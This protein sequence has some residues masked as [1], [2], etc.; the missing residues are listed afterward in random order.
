NTQNWA[1]RNQ[2][3]FETIDRGTQARATNTLPSGSANGTKSRSI[4]G[5]RQFPPGNKEAALTKIVDDAWAKDLPLLHESG[6][7]SASTRGPLVEGSKPGG[8]IESHHEDPPRRAGSATHHPGRCADGDLGG[9]AGADLHVSPLRRFLECPAEIMH[10]IPAL[11][12]PERRPA[13]M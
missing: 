1:S 3:P 12:A 7:G 4:T 5:Y 9:T 10:A 6:S 8:P 13:N 2:P 11:D